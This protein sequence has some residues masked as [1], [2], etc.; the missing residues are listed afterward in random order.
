M[1]CS[2]EIVAERLEAHYGTPRWRRHA[3]PLDELVMTILSQH[4]S[5]GNTAAAFASLRRRFPTWEQVRRAAS[6][7]VVAA[8]RGGGLGNRKGPR[9]Q[10][11][12]DAIWHDRGRLDLDDYVDLP[13]S[14]VRTRL[15]ALSGV[16]PK[17]AACVQL[18]S[19]GQPAL[20][21]DT[22]VHRVSRRVG[23]VP[24]ATSAQAAQ[25]ILERLL[26]ADRDR[27]YAFHLNVIAHGRSICRARSPACGRCP[28]NDCCDA[29]LATLQTPPAGEDP[30]SS[31]PSDGR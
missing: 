9:I 6:S 19:L 30:H 12:L 16:G 14:E 13:Q 3:P 28:L 24:P 4:T 25:P 20:P 10:A 5:D 29:Y 15:L 31:R 23:L 7:D 2:I 17:T 1:S 11:V 18:F 8:I 27:V 21:V 22:H 26:G